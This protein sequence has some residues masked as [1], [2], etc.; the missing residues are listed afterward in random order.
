MRLTPRSTAATT[1]LTAPQTQQRRGTATTTG[2][3]NSLGTDRQ[4]AGATARVF[5]AG[6]AMTAIAAVGAGTIARHG[7]AAKNMP[8]LY[9]IS[10]LKPQSWS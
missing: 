5:A 4:Q 2:F 8:R 3:R 7:E 1:A 6:G 9:R 10:G